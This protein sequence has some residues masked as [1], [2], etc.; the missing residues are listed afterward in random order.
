MNQP[1]QNNPSPAQNIPASNEEDK[2]SVGAEQPTP[3][4]FSGSSR[5]PDFVADSVENYLQSYNSIAEWIRFADAK[6]AVVLT[7][8]GALAS[9]LIPTLKPFLHQRMEQLGMIPGRWQWSLFVANDFS[10]VIFDISLTC[11]FLWLG[12]LVLSGTFAFLCISPYRRKGR[13]PAL[14]HCSNFHPA[15]IAKKYPMSERQ[16]FIEQ[17]L[18]QGMRGLEKQVL[19]GILIDSHISNLKYSRVT[20]SIRFFFLSAVFGFGYMLMKQL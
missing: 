12:L 1:P 13:H 6:A 15:A 10:G 16:L 20:S 5:S 8:N 11:F 18:Q 17:T 3:S 2:K 9:I 7:V 4:G 14:E 19:T